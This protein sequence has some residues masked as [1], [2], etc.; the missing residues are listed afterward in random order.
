MLCY[1]MQ[2]SARE[3]VAGLAARA[4]SVAEEEEEG[5]MEGRGAAREEA[6]RAGG[7]MGAR[8]AGGMGAG[9]IVS[10]LVWQGAG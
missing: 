1:V 3:G 8:V 6:A 9:G 2:A 5:S 7:M 4:H 10:V